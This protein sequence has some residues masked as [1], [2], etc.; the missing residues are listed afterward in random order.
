[1][2]PNLISMVLLVVWQAILVISFEASPYEQQPYALQDSACDGIAYHKD[3]KLHS[4]VAFPE[5]IVY[6]YPIGMKHVT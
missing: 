5:I 4:D 2:N 6:V 1:M 3:D